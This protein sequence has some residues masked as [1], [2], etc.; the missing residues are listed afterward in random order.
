MIPRYQPTASMQQSSTGTY[1]AL[2]DLE[3]ALE[4]LKYAVHQLENVQAG[5][6]TAEEALKS[7]LVATQLEST[8]MYRVL[9]LGE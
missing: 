8:D 5:R 1:V 2:A 4:L 9:G 7:V 6:L 3:R